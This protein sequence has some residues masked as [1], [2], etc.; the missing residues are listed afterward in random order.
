VPAQKAG[1][2]GT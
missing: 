1:V 2:P